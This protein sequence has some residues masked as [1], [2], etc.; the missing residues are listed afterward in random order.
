[1]RLRKRGDVYYARYYADG[2]R[3]TKST[4]CTD[5][6]AAEARAR[7]WERDAADPD[8]ATQDKATVASALAL[9]LV[10]RSSDAK[11]GRRS[12]DTVSFYRVKSGHVNRLLGETRLRRLH[13]GHVDEYIRLRRDEGASESTIAKELTA[14]R[15]SLKIA[16]RARLWRG[17]PSD[18]CPVAFS[19]AYKPRERALSLDEVQLVLRELPNDR[20][21]QVAYMVAAGAEWGAIGR[22]ERTDVELWPTEAVVLV[23]GT[24]RAT[25]WRSVPVVLPVGV[26]LLRFAMSKAEGKSPRLFTPW[27]NVRRDLHEACARAKIDPFS[28]ND[29]RRTFATWLRIGGATPDVIAPAMGHCDSRMVERVYG[30]L[31]PTDLASRLAS[32]LG[33]AGPPVAQTPPDSV[34]T[35]DSADGTD[36]QNHAAF[37]AQRRNRTADTGIF[38]PRALFVSSGKERRRSDGGVT[39]GPLMAHRSGVTMPRGKR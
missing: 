6:K 8:H 38:N 5:K 13:A 33:I 15:A 20:A 25:R 22:A 36:A 17:D 21:A 28:P 7:E 32:Q 34:D 12:E 4:Q 18:V 9:L 2:E 35:V 31:K 39:R 37:G 23:R 24:K 10:S 19:P 3:V 14:L 11:A 16:K 26:E 30:R 29:L 1:M 27:G